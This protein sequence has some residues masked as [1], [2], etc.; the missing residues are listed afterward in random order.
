MRK[1]ALG[2]ASLSVLALLSPSAQATAEPSFARLVQAGQVPYVGELVVNGRTVLRVTHGAGDRRRQE[3]VS[4]ARMAGE[5]VVDNGKTRWHYSPRTQRVDITP[6]TLGLRR[7]MVS[8]RL[9]SRNFR[10]EVGSRATVLGRPTRIVEI[11]PLHPGRSRQRLWMDVATGLALRTEH[12]S[13]S[14]LVLDRSEFRS[15]QVQTALKPDA[16]EF[17]LPPRAKVGSSVQ[18]LAS[19]QTLDEIDVELPFTPR[20]PSYLPAGFE[21]LDV[22][23]FESKGVRNVHWRLSDGLGM[24]SL[25]QATRESMPPMP[26]DAREVTFEGGR[27][28][29]LGHGSHRMLCWEMPNGSYSLVGD[30]AQSELTKIAASTAP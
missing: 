20:L 14:G 6:S 30:L 27:G 17:T 24:L 23:V 26:E 25:F 9:L 21:V 4:P 12:L 11:V 29:V 18:V 1:F 22:Q 2:I 28:H 13:P 7:P 15:I 19:G 16:F 10:L 5:L 3:V 8:E